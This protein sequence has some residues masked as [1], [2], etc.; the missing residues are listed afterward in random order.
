MLW[1]KAI[2]LICGAV[3][4]LGV[5]YAFQRPFREYPG[6][7]YNDFP[8]P[9]DFQEKTEW[10]FARLMYPSAPTARFVGYRRYGRNNWTEGLT[11]WTQDYPRADRHFNLAIRR[12]TRDL[13]GWRPSLADC[14][15]RGIPPV[16]A[17]A[18]CPVRKQSRTP[19]P[20]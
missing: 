14:A 2:S 16:R 11:S 10:V 1:R 5:L 9:A 3:A 12:L 6:I 13:S 15:A 4:F 18:F 19:A 8:L 17:E 20:I 7:E